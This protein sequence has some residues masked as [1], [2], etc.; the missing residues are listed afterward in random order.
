MLAII[1][2]RKKDYLIETSIWLYVTVL[3][4]RVSEIY[5]DHV[6]GFI[7]SVPQKTASVASWATV[8]TLTMIAI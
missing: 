1:L 6:N 4:L 8:L 2:A 5:C 7:P 3:F